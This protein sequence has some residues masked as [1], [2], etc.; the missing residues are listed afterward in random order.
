M[1][2]TTKRN[3]SRRAP[4]DV[5]TYVR[6]YA[7]LAS[8]TTARDDNVYSTGH[9]DESIKSEMKHSACLLIVAMNVL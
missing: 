2:C 8:C 7:Q 5:G 1:H 4:A 6:T 3:R 9:T